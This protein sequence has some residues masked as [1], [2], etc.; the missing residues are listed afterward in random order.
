[1]VEGRYKV[2][3]RVYVCANCGVIRRASKVFVYLRQ[4]SWEEAMASA[5]WPKHCG[6]PMEVLTYV[7]AEGATQLTQDERVKW[8]AKGMHVLRQHQHGSHKWKPVMADWQIEEAR[9]QR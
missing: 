2:S 5:R 4:E 6:Q 3:N 8:V 7:Q 1:M 9:R